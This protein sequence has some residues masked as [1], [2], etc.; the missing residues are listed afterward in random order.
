MPKKLVYPK[1]TAVEIEEECKGQIFVLTQADRVT[2][3]V[4][5]L[6][7]EDGDIFSL[8]VKTINGDIHSIKTGVEIYPDLGLIVYSGLFNINYR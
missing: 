7:A 4:G 3:T 2:Q 6:F 5:T 8:R 1:N